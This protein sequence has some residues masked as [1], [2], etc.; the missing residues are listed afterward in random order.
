M[1]DATGK[2]FD[3]GD[4]TRRSLLIGGAAAALTGCSALGGAPELGGSGATSIVDA[5]MHIFDGARPQGAAPSGSA[6]YN[7]FT[8]LNKTF[9]PREYAKLAAPLGI[10]GAIVVEASPWLEDNLWYLDRAAD[11]PL[12]LGVVGQL[13]AAEPK[14]AEY[15]TRFGKNPLYQGIR[16]SDYFRLGANQRVE[17]K[18]GVVEAMKLMA[19]L[20]LTLDSFGPTLD[21]LRA[22]LLLTDAVPNLRIVLD[23]QPRYDPTPEQLPTY[24]A[25][26]KDLAARPNI[27]CKLTQI[28]H[29][30]PDGSVQR[31]YDVLTEEIEF[32]FSQFGEDRVIFGT[33]YPNNYNLADMPA[34]LSIMRRFFATKTPAQ[35]EKYFWRNSARVYKWTRRR[36]DQ[37]QPV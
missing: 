35:A 27:A 19:D 22:N 14:F 37:P 33:D 31:D 3:V 4:A 17:L 9:L 34:R 18:P 23:H 25:L 5:H 24:Q 32:L 11:D 20:D 30:A 7:A 10:V 29:T 36:N 8:A 1:S 28:Y 21:Q 2:D 15:L 12:V 16:Y 13:D 6:S 26:V